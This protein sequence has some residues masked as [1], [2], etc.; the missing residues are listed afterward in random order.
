MNYLPEV[1]RIIDSYARIKQSLAVLDEQ[2]KLLSL[3]KNSIEFE[4]AQTREAEA[5]LIDRIKSET[6]EV[7]DFYKMVQQLDNGSI[8]IY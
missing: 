1:K 5:N 3:Q 6:G 8:R 7:P 4:L 2:T